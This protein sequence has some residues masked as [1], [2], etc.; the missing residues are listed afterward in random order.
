MSAQNGANH[1][2]DHGSDL[3]AARAL[4]L[5]TEVLLSYDITC[6]AGPHLTTDL[7]GHYDVDGVSLAFKG[8]LKVIVASDASH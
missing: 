4:A 7:E 3:D 5:L 2:T 1:P 6:L 8:G